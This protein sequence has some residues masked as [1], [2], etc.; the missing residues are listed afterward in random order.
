MELISVIIPAY[1]AA[2]H[3]PQAV[4]SVVAQDY[5]RVETIVIADDGTDYAPLLARH[6]LQH[7]QVRHLSTGGVGLGAPF[8]R[9]VGIDA[10]SG[11]L[12]ALLDADDAFK[13]EKLS[14]CASPALEHGAVSC[15]LEI[16]QG[17]KPVRTVGTDAKEGT[18]PASCYKRTNI[19]M[20]TMLVYDREALPVRFEHPFSCLQDLEFLLQIFTR[21]PGLYHLPQPLHEYHKRP[22]SISNAA[23]SHAKYR[24]QKQVILKRIAQGY[25]AF[26]DPGAA[27]AMAD[28]INASLKAEDALEQSLAHNPN[29]LFEDVME[30]VLNAG[31]G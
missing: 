22:G 9:N 7:A 23:D 24:R 12:I 10:A 31:S 6:G 19:S 29:I 13:P 27:Q 2:E 30:D 5:P 17:D 8:A 15:G 25:Y 26:C 3:L 4:A 11:R 28:F 20:D 21:L 14:R 1:R 16:W 18:L